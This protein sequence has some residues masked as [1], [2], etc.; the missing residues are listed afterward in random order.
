MR[1]LFWGVLLVL[2][3]YRVTVGSAVFEVLPDF[4]GWFLVLKGMEE[5]AQKSRVFDRM[6]HWAFGLSVVSAILYGAE[7]FNLETM[8]RVWLWV[9]GLGILVLTL[10]MLRCIRRGLEEL[11]GSGERLKAMG[12]ILAV[13]LPICY[14][15][16]WVP[17]VGSVCEAAAAVV[18]AL[19]LLTLF[20]EMKKSAE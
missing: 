17:V 7:L 14:L 20:G 5:L 8:T 10:W 16:S 2:L 15:V 18:S 13:L 4:L 6:R 3:D 19:Y 12:L 11:V 9:M 1:R